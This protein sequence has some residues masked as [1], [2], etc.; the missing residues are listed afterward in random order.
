MP[1]EL[2][3]RET[4]LEKIKAAMSALGEEAEQQAPEKQKAKEATFKFNLR[5]GAGTLSNGCSLKNAQCNSH[6]QTISIS[7]LVLDS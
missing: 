2:K 7:S 3:R 5:V 4:C 1:E 6:W